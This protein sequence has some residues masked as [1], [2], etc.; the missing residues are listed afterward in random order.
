MA[1]TKYGLNNFAFIV[2]ELYPEKINVENNKKL[3]DL[4]DFY[5]KCLLPN[6]NILTEAGS[7]FGYKY[8]EITRIKMKAVYSDE[9]RNAIGSLNK[10]KLL[11]EKTKNKMR[12]GALLRSPRVF[13][14]KTLCNLKKKI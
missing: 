6:Y 5:L 1:T 2:V 14:D 11:S 9:G 3:L 13:Y 12:E 8:T 10:G 4:E 7:N